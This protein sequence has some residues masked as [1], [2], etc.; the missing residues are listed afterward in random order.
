MPSTDTKEQAGQRGAGGA[1]LVSV[2]MPAYR[3]APYIGAALESVFAQTVTDYEIVVVNDG[4]PDTPD[5]ERAL[6]PYRGRVHYIE[7]ENRGPGAARNAGILRARG[8]YVAFLDSDDVWL[9]EYLA[10][11]LG[12][13][14]RDPALDLVY[15][16]AVLFGDSL[17][18]GKT[19][20]EIWPS[21]GP[22]T[23][24]S[25]FKIEVAPINVCTVAR[26]E[27]LIAVGLF[28]EELRRAEDFHL[29]ARLAHRGYRFGYQ[30]KVLARVR[31]HGQ[32][33]TADSISLFEDQLRAC[34]KLALTLELAPREREL[35]NRRA[36][37]AE[38]GLALEHGKRLL[39]AGEFGGARAELTR[40][41]DFYKSGKLRATLLALRTAPG[42]LKRVYELRNGLWSRRARAGARE[43]N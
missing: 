37:R 6:A 26:R 43:V 13:L 28:D 9:P 8:T 22:V 25:L 16:D 11:Q 35:L 17:L 4:S 19:I 30:R 41:N 24:E 2:V 32:S 3:S 14:R 1:P 36:A 15:A 10:E 39:A 7:Q 29:Y 27:A 21:V 33:L 38:A 23:L 40:A 5:L 42:L 31:L 20:M 34:R 18:A 12:A